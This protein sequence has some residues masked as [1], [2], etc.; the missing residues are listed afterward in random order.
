YDVT[1][2]ALSGAM[3]ITGDDD[4]DAPPVRWGHPIGGLA[5][6]LYGTIA[7]L[8]ALRQAKRGGSG[9][10]ID[11]SLLDVQIALHAY[12]VPQAL[13]LGAQFRPQPNQGGSGARPYG[14]FLTKD[15]RW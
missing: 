3:S 7:V 12:R 14:P 4:P 6:G 1:L 2:Q 11:L 5:G 10:H 9:R 8:G 15:G 13:T